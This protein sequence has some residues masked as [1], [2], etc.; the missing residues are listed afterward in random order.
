MIFNQRNLE[1]E[2]TGKNCSVPSDPLSRLRYFLNCL[3]SV[4][5]LNE[6]GKLSSIINYQRPISLSQSEID[7][8]IELCKVSFVALDKKCIFLAPQLC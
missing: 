2:K 3:C 8:L 6:N 1:V 5:P 7:G 4:V